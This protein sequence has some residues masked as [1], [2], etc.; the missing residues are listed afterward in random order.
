MRAQATAKSPYIHR[1]SAA[2]IQSHITKKAEHIAVV[3][4]PQ[5]KPKTHVPHAQHVRAVHTKHPE[6]KST[7]EQLFNKA[8]ENATPPPKTKHKTRKRSKVAKR[9]SIASTVLASFLLV[10]F[11]AY[12]NWPNLNLRLASSQAGFSAELPSYQ[13]SGYSFAGPVSFEAGKVTVNFKS[14]TDDRA[15]SVRQEV[16]SWN[17]QSLEDNYLSAQNKT[18]EI[19]Q[20]GG[21]TIYLYDKGKATWV[22]G[23]VWYQIDGQSLSPDQLVKIASSL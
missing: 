22:N 17:S 14:N 10:G 15:Y 19:Q 23:G 7:S 12:L 2:P 21:R 11:I 13:P 20:E 6:P 16:S 8:L 1:Y 5:D 4:P 3:E 18:F 9:S